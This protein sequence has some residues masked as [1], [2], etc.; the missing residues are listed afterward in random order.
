MEVADYFP[1]EC[2]VKRG[3]GGQT[4]GEILGRVKSDVLDLEPAVVVVLAGINDLVHEVGIDVQEQPVDDRR[5]CRCERYLSSFCSVLPV[6]PQKLD[7]Q[8][9][10]LP[11]Q[12]ILEINVW[13]REHC[14]TRDY[15]YLDYF[16][17]MVDKNGFLRSDLA[18]DGVHPNAA[19]YKIMEGLVRRA[20][21]STQARTGPSTRS[22]LNQ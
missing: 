11:S 20:L 5:S 7:A 13:L 10:A 8:T 3:I 14:R 4:S 16:S 17:A 18:S 1:G 21:L 22:G 15:L 19:G 12:K 2:F 6:D 9:P